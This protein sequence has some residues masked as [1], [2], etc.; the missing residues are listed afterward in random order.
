MLMLDLFVAFRSMESPSASTDTLTSQIQDDSD[1][2]VEP[3]LPTLKQVLGED[4]V[5][6]LK[7]KEKKRQDVINGT[8]TLFLATF[9]VYEVF[10][11]VGW[12]ENFVEKF[13]QTKN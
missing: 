13:R 12:K 9:L 10:S 8:K 7:P 6:K 4:T 3:D 5:R 2:E 11:F 1:F